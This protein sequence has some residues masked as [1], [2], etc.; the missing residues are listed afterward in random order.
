MSLFFKKRPQYRIA[1]LGAGKVAHHL[2]PA[3]EKA[4]HQVVAVYSRRPGQA[5]R[6]TSHLY[7]ADAIHHTDFRT[8][9]AEVFIIA[10]SDDAISELAEKVKLPEGILLVHT[11]GGRS[12]QVL[13]NAATSNIGVLYPLQ[14][15]SLDKNV[16]FR[17]VP[18]LVEANSETALKQVIQLAES[19]S[20]DVVAVSS[21]QRQWL[22]TGAVFACN[23]SNHMLHLAEEML[24]KEGLSFELLRPLIQETFQKAL[25]T[26]PGLAQTGPA[27]RNDQTS[28][29]AHVQLLQQKEPE[30]ANLYKK[31]SESIQSYLAPSRFHARV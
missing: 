22:H 3:L 28:M 12:M 4:G 23:F 21:G 25:Q 1:V 30:L 29:Q 10:V 13:Q 11:S 20:E 31:I 5:E 24:E 26:G 2:A 14:T 17:N 19:L 7:E 15:F 18:M 8:S 6:I 9:Q 16:D 27:I